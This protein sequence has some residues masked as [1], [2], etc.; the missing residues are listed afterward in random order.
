[1]NKTFNKTG[2]TLIEIILAVAIASSVLTMIYGSFVATS[3][4]VKACNNTAD[5]SQHSQKVLEMMAKQIRCAYQDTAAKDENS[6]ELNPRHEQKLYPNE[7]NY[8]SG[9]TDGS[10]PEI[11]HFVTTG[12]F[13]QDQEKQTNLLDIIYRF[14]KRSNILLLSQQK[15]IKTSNTAGRPKN[16]EPVAYKIKDIQLEFYDGQKWTRKWESKESKNLPV[17]VKIQITCQGENNKQYDYQTVSY[18]ACSGYRYID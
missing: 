8:F 13:L 12:D 1:M 4:T 2:F 15:Y 11:L 7:N 17:A 10:N 3:R 16:F 9:C 6:L 5:L 14:D 18:V